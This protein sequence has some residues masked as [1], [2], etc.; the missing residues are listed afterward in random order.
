MTFPH[1]ILA[2]GGK[3]A[4]P[5][6]LRDFEYVGVLCLQLLGNKMEERSGEEVS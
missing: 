4:P 5:G 3:E 1:T 2:F 6:D